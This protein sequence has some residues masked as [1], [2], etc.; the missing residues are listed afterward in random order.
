MKFIFFLVCLLIISALCTDRSRRH[1][2]KYRSRK[3][4]GYGESC[5]WQIIGSECG[6]SLVCSGGICKGKFGFV[7][8]TKQNQCDCMMSCRKYNGKTQCIPDMS[9]VQ[10]ASLTK[11]QMQPYTQCINDDETSRNINEETLTTSREIYANCINK[12]NRSFQ[13][14]YDMIQK[15]ELDQLQ[16]S[17]AEVTSDYLTK[18][19]LCF[20]KYLP[21]GKWRPT[22]DFET[23]PKPFWDFTQKQSTCKV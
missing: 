11:S 4:K 18:L 21:S 23:Y 6:S 1:K 12:V 15:D 17:K 20:G 19:C 5:Q 3:G 14:K 9:L 2:L 13:H 16:V 22:A 10:F 8:S 7:C